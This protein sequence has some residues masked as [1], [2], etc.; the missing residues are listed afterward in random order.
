MINSAKASVVDKFRKSIS[1]KN[2]SAGA[3]SATIVMCE[4]RLLK[5][6]RCSAGGS[7]ACVE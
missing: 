6:I 3:C 5:V 2:I 1:M 7:E 4:M